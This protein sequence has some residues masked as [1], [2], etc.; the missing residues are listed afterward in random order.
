VDLAL[1]GGGGVFSVLPTGIET[2]LPFA[3]NAPFV[4]DPARLKIKD[5]A[6]RQRIDGFFPGSDGLLRRLSPRWAGDASCR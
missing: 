6:P 5:P 4:P 3:C 2:K 1:V